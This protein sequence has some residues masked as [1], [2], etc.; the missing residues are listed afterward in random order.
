MCTGALKIL[1]GFLSLRLLYTGRTRQRVEL[2]ARTWTSWLCDNLGGWGILCATRKAIYWKAWCDLSFAEFRSNK[3]PYPLSVWNCGL[4]EI[5][6]THLQFGSWSVPPIFHLCW[7][8]ER[9]ADK[10]CRVQIQVTFNRLDYWG[11]RASLPFCIK[12]PV[13]T[14]KNLHTTTFTHT[15]HLKIWIFFKHSEF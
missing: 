14:F 7:S 9:T 10:L 13:Q 3:S 12:T 8:Q 1:V 11:N 4:Y 6:Q 2:T 15:V 5:L